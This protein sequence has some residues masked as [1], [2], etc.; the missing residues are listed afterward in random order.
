RGTYTSAVMDATQI[1]RFGKMHLH[2]S[3]P[4]GTTLTVSTR[5]GNVKEPEEKGW[6]KWTDEAPATEYFQIAS[7]SAR[8][9]QYRLTFTSKEGRT[10]PVVEDV[11]VAYQVP[12]LAPQIKAVRIGNAGAPANPAEALVAAAGAS[13]PAGGENDLR[14][15]ESARVQTIAWD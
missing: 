9:L 15:V 11:N 12:N 3:L 14:R 8:F 13:N 6:S 2:G 10:S 5:S 1:S 4:A 7:P